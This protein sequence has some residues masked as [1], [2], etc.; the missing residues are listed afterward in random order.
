MCGL[1]ISSGQPRCNRYFTDWNKTGFKYHWPTP[2]QWA[3]ITGACQQDSSLI[4]PRTPRNQ[5]TRP[6]HG[7]CP[8]AAPACSPRPQP[9]PSSLSKGTTQPQHTEASGSTCAQR[10][11][12]WLSL[13]ELAPNSRKC[14]SHVHPAP[15]RAFLSELKNGHLSRAHKELLPLNNRKRNYAPQTWAKDW[16]RRVFKEDIHVTNRHEKMLGTISH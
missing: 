5:F 6:G 9:T 12:T 8:R 4:S 11:T 15:Q 10:A 1:H 13:N 14:T 2:G 16:N 3:G 7:A